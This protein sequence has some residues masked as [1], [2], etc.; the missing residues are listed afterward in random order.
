VSANALG[1]TILVVFSIGL[2]AVLA[3]I[4]MVSLGFGSV[5]VRNAL[6]TAASFSGAAIALLTAASRPRGTRA[7]W[8]LLGLGILSYS[9]G[10]LLFFFVLKTLT[11][12]PSTADLS[13]LAFYP[14][15]V[16]A[17]ILLARGQRRSERLALS[18]TR[19]S[20]PWQ[21]PPSAMS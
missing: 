19:Q 3:E 16:A 20:S 12:F 7:A 15:V 4:A 6:V 10:S 1:P 8:L 21:L 11:T 2:C 5:T 17:I 9:L 14:L 18:S 13:W